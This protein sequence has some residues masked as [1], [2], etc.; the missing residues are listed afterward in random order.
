MKNLKITLIALLFIT[1]FS[2]CKKDEET[3]VVPTGS[4]SANFRD[5]NAASASWSATSTVAVKT[6]NNYVI[7][8]KGINNSTLVITVSNITAAGTYNFDSAARSAVFTYNNITY[9]T[10]GN[11]GGN[12]SITSVTAN[13]IEGTFLAEMFSG[14][15]YGSLSSGKFSATF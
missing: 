4:A 6:G 12:V 7:T 15:T 14:T 5:A 10:V 3:T 2:A 11:G 9:T 8:A 1:A 13:S